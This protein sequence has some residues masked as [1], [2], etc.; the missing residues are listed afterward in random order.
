MMSALGNSSAKIVLPP[1]AFGDRLHISEI[2][3]PAL[4]LRMPRRDDGRKLPR[5]AAYIRQ[6]LVFGKVE[7]LGERREIAHG[8]AA[9]RVH[10]LLQSRW[11]C[12][13]LAEHGLACLLDLVLRLSGFQ[14]GREIG[15]EP[16]Q[17][18]VRHLEYPTDVLGALLDQEQCG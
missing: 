12:I 16:I 18:C 11:V 8:D 17:A 9:H 3:R 5:C 7:F 13:E 1:P 15:P 14:R 10:E 6:G 2:A 4:Y